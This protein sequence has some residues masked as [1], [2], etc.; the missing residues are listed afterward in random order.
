MALLGKPKS[1]WDLYKHNLKELLCEDKF[2][3]PLF[4]TRTHITNIDAEN[5]TTLSLSLNEYFYMEPTLHVDG[6]ILMENDIHCLRLSG[7]KEAIVVDLKVYCNAPVEKL[8]LQGKHPH[9]AVGNV[10]I[11]PFS[12]DAF[13][14]FNYRSLQ[15]KCT[16]IYGVRWPYLEGIPLNEDYFRDLEEH[17]IPI[18]KNFPL[19]IGNYRLTLRS[20]N[21]KIEQIYQ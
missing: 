8:H 7:N 1:K 13:K 21:M 12:K 15:G 14:D 6:D 16:G 4:T 10:F 20:G 19:L 5:D 2:G 11:F 9:N 3:A 18:L 17:L